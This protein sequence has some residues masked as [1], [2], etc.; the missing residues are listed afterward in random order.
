MDWM[1]VPWLASISIAIFCWI[2]ITLCGA[3]LVAS[4]AGLITFLHH[5]EFSLKKNPVKTPNPQLKTLFRLLLGV[6]LWCGLEAIWSSGPLWWSSL[7]YTQSPHNLFILHLTQLSGP[8]TVT[9]AI[10]AV[11]GL[12]AEAAI[13]YGYTQN[14]RS[15]DAPPSQFGKNLGYIL[16]PPFNKGG[17][18]G[19]NHGNKQVSLAKRDAPREDGETKNYSQFRKESITYF[20]LAIG[21]LFILHAIGFTLYSRPLNQPAETSLKVGIIQ[22]NIPNRIKLYPEGWYRAIEGYTTGYEQ[23]ADEGVQAVLTPETALPFLWKNQVRYGSSF[24]SAILDKGVLAWVGGFGEKDGSL[25]N[26]LFTVIGTG[27]TF[28]HYDKV[29]LVPLGEYIPF[30]AV[31]GK[32]IN[33]LSPLNADLVPG[34]PNQIFNTPFG[35]AIVGICYESA[36]TNHFRQQAANGGEF[37]L[38]ASNNAHYSETMPAQHHAQDVIRAIETSRWAVRATNTG[39]SGIVDP[40]GKTIWISRIN[41]YQIHADRI[42]RRQNQTLYV[43]WGDWLT[44]LLLVLV[45]LIGVIL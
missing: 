15:W 5:W 1:G 16:P 28:S 26:S 11:N 14:L 9:G 31:L 21:L 34:K 17:W 40:H 19:E 25:T 23:L 22:G 2:F 43:Q 41:Q 3:A 33:R 20:S 13:S 10:V 38:T 39:Y 42:Y 24:Y 27:E 12:L 29:K 36:F 45:T 44:P 32:L 35:K 37:I 8:E 18:G 4:W 7:S 30:Q 6:S